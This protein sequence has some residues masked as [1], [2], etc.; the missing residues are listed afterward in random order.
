MLIIDLNS[1]PRLKSSVMNM[2]MEGEKQLCN[3]KTKSPQQALL[4]VIREI[5]FTIREIDFTTS[6]VKKPN[7]LN[8]K[9]KI[10]QNQKSFIY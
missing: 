8:Q 1:R 2:A 10:W 6:F 3:L 9:W 4:G 7:I 5:D